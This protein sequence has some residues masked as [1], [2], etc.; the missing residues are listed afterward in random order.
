MISSREISLTLGLGL[1]M[2]ALLS[3]SLVP[4]AMGTPATNGQVVVMPSPTSGSPNSLF[5][6]QSSQYLLSSGEAS[7]MEWVV[8]L[9]PTGTGYV[10]AAPNC[11]VGIES[12]TPSLEG[13]GSCTVPFGAAGSESVGSTGAI[14]NDFYCGN[15]NPVWMTLTSGTTLSAV[16]SDCTGASSPSVASPTLVDGSTSASGA[17]T[18]IACWTTPGSSGGGTTPYVYGT[19]TFTVSGASAVPQFPLGFALLFA[20][21]FPAMLVLRGIYSRRSAVGA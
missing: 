9:S 3:L 12:P 8:V 1:G 5:N 11:G 19:G 16:E 10:C 18:A 13:A 7:T 6:I 21:A 15:S 14:V 20:A 2:M 17:Y 4:G